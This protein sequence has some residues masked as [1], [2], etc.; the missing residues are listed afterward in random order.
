M[1][2]LKYIRNNNISTIN[3]NTI[4]VDYDLKISG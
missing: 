1:N 4:I 3:S 2:N